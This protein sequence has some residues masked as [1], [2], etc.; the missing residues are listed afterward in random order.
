MR[1]VIF[2]VVLASSATA[3]AQAAAP[4]TTPSDCWPSS[5]IDTVVVRMTDGTVRRGSL[6]CL[7]DQSFSL[8]EKSRIGRYELREVQHI[9]KAAD[10][11][12]D[13][14]AKG[15]SVGLVLL[16]FCGRHCPGEVILRTAL[17]YGM[18]GLAI[19][20]I[21][22]HTDTIYRASPGKRVAAAFRV[23]F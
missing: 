11:V 23:G 12:W 4:S 18:F 22:T 16:A 3:W 20:A 8:A 7:G 21:D 2:V 17:G 10:P 9:R 6:L 13:G 19:D 1:I 14:A 15:A 5:H